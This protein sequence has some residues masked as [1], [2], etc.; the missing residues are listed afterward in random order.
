MTLPTRR[1]WF[2]VRQARMCECTAMC[3]SYRSNTT[4]IELQQMLLPLPL[5]ATQFYENLFDFNHSEETLPFSVEFSSLI[6]NHHFLYGYK[7]VWADCKLW[8][9]A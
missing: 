1:N 4:R 3:S 9:A 8:L 2:E 5:V 7:L 6:T